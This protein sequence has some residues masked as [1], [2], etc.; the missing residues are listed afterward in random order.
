MITEY[1]R[2]IIEKL[3]ARLGTRIPYYISEIAWSLPLLEAL[4]ARI[5]R[6]EQSTGNEP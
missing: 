4:V 3:A 6:L 1:E 2:D 5:E